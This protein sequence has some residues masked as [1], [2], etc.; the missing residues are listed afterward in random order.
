MIRHATIFVDE[1]KPLNFC[2]KTI[3]YEMNASSFELPFEI[4][5]TAGDHDFTKCEGCQ[6]TLG[7]LT[8]RLKEKFEGSETKKGFP[9]C[10]PWHSNLTKKVEKFSR[11]SF[12]NVPEWNGVGNFSDSSCS[13]KFQ[14]LRDWN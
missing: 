5:S 10:C 2:G 11:A 14:H 9:F 7:E 6:K 3:G 13:K 12:V 8:K 1:L 4:K